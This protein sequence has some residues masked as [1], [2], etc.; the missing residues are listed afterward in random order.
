VSEIA[1]DS[2]TRLPDGETGPRAE[3]IWYQIPRLAAN[4]SLE[5]GPSVPQQYVDL[6][7]FKLRAGVDPD[8]VVF[9]LGFAAAAAESYAVFRRLKKDGVIRPDVK[10]QVG[11]PT[12][13]AVLGVFVSLE[14]Q[15]RLID[16]YERQLA[17]EVAR[18]ADTVPH[19]E[20]ALQWEVAVE[21][22]I[23]EKATG[24]G[25]DTTGLL[26]QLGRLA[27][28]VPVDVT[29]G[30]HL[31]YGDAPIEPGGVGRHFMQPKD[32]ANLAMVA[33]GILDRVR[34]PV[35]FIHLPVP[36]DRDDDAY[37][38]PLA[39]LRLPATTKLYLGLVH[40]QDGLE[41]TQRRADVA[42]RHVS[43]FGVA[44]ECGMGR[45]PRQVVPDLLRI[46]RDV[47]VNG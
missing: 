14:D 43:G 2:V 23:I 40:H 41:G 16:G 33:R 34:R 46:Q 12:Q 20:L 19:A 39:D 3:W 32:T 21:F 30:F 8:D 37:F 13:V 35:G 26:D 29:L 5:P 24:S 25:Y 18:I 27:A 1:G 6:P 15:P 31:C 7:A 44:T 22:S 11:V 42:A 38:E 28:M 36:I 10:F 9:D 47:R 17:Q 45:R 4:P